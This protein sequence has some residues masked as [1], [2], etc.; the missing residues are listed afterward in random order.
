M[1]KIP[2]DEKEFKKH[3]EWLRKDFLAKAAAKTPEA[4]ADILNEVQVEK[5]VEKEVIKEVDNPENL[6]R[7]DKLEADN[8][9][10]AEMVDSK[11]KQIEEM[12]NAL[13]QAKVIEEANILAKGTIERQEKEIETLKKELPSLK[14]QVTKLK[15]AL[16][17]LSNPE[18]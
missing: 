10:L 6:A 15:N 3:E 16:K 13:K 4:F 8:T 14:T 9:L 18:A 12:N 7:I 5:V 11:N 1:I 17:E 2:F